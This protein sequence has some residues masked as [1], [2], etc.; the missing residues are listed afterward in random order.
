MFL[1]YDEFSIV[2]LLFHVSIDKS[3]TIRKIQKRLKWFKTR[4]INDAYLK[5][6]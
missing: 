2:E 1:S 4:R 5:K 6:E 3:L